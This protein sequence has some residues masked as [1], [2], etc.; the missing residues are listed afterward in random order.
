M[1]V[2]LCGLP[3]NGKGTVASRLAA[4]HGFRHTKFA[5]PLKD[6]LRVMIR[7]AGMDEEFIERLIEGDLKETPQPLMGNIT[8]RWAMQTLGTA[9][10]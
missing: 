5:G 8:P 4:K 6:M 3:S 2:G 1:L 7:H 10:S 9:V